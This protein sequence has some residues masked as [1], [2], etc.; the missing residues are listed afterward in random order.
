MNWLVPAS[1][2]Q[3][4]TLP[5]AACARS[6]LACAPSII[7]LALSLCACATAGKYGN[8]PS[9]DISVVDEKGEAIAGE[10]TLFGHDVKEAC[11]QEGYSCSVDIPSGNFALTFRKLRAGRLAGL[12]SASPGSSM[13]TGSGGKLAG[14]LRTRVHATAGQKLVCKKSGDWGC[15]KGMWT[16]LDCGPAALGLQARPADGL[17]D[18]PVPA[19]N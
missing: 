18:A 12:G 10:I 8:I 11:V 13:S 9:T 5:L 17:D 3:L 16:N 6:I 14:C 2:P 4:R 7:A 19:E 1:P 15:F